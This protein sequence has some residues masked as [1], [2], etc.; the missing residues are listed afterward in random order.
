MRERPRVKVQTLAGRLLFST[1]RIEAS[2]PNRGTNRGSVGTGFVFAYGFDPEGDKPAFFM[3]TNKHV[4]EDAEE[5]SFVFIENDGNGNPALGQ[6]IK[7]PVIRFK[8]VWHGHPD[9]DVDIAVSPIRSLIDIRLEAG[10][11]ATIGDRVTKPFS[12]WL[13]A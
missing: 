10:D 7:V 9:P 3:V 4:I 8:E 13:D 5:G 6:G 11:P 1:V 2:R 12:A